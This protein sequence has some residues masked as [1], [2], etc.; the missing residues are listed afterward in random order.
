MSGK[1]F[2]IMENIEILDLK[3]TEIFFWARDEENTVFSYLTL[4][5]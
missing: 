3:R 5:L 1:D 2:T 4:K